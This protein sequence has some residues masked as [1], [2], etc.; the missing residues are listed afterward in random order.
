[1]DSTTVAIIVIA[2]IGGVLAGLAVGLITAQRMEAAKRQPL[3]EALTEAQRGLAERDDRL[4]ALEKSAAALSTQLDDRVAR[5]GEVQ[6]RLA[7]TEARTQELDRAGSS[8]RATLGER[9]KALAERGQLLDQ[10]RETFASLSQEA[11]SRSSE[12][13]LKLAQQRFETLSQA[14]QGDLATRQEAIKGLVDPLADSLKRYEGALRALEEKRQTAYA[15]LDERLKGL[16]EAEVRLQQETTKLVNALRRPEVRG[17]WGE[18]QLRNAVE[19]AGMSQYCDFTEQV[20]VEGGAQ[21]P[22]MVVNLPGGKRIVVDAKVPLDAYLRAVEAADPDLHRQCMIEHATQCRRHLEGLTRKAYWEQFDDAPD[23]VIMFVPGE[24][25]F[26]AAVEADSAL[27]D[28]GLRSKVVMATPATLIAM[29]YAVSYGW[30]QQTFTENA[31]MV[32]TLAAEMYDRLCV[33]AEHFQ[34]VGRAL[35]GSV[36]AYNKAVGSLES[37]VMVSARRLKETKVSERDLPDVSPLEVVSRQLG[38]ELS[39]LPPESEA[40]LPEGEE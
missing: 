25:L 3:A 16:S 20:S 29:L 38:P 4:L 7:E 34:G 19:M 22:D 1:M 17:R 18:M 8:L 35:N 28:Y 9:D 13:F 40:G 2:A 33:F 24:S 5:L 26:A 21:R 32:R 27:L 14:A 39:A 10:M 15:S 36:G 6:S 30:R 37:R 23:C 11:L 31:E 12:D